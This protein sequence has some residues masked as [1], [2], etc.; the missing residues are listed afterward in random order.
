[1]RN[2]L[3]PDYPR[4]A[5]ACLILGGIWLNLSVGVRRVGYMRQQLR[6][7]STN[8]KH[9]NEVALRG[10]IQCYDRSY[11]Q[12]VTTSWYN[13]KARQLP[14]TKNLKLD[15]GYVRNSTTVAQTKVALCRTTKMLFSWPRAA[16]SVMW[17]PSVCPSVPSA[18]SP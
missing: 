11:R 7:T 2:L 9:V 5:V 16:N 14:E 15:E 3:L 17:R 10:S 6:P 1:L 8:S 12:H 18:Y 13:S 4:R